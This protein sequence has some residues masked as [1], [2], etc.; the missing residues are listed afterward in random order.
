MKKLKEHWEQVY[1]EKQINE[2]SWY[3]PKPETSLDF[4][5][6]FELNKDEK[7]IDVGGGDSF[8]VDH[9]LS[10]GF[11]D[12]TVLDISETAISRAKERLGKK[13]D[14]IT[15]IVED[16]ASFRPK[17]TYKLWHDR[18]AFHFLTEEDQIKNYLE[19]LDKAVAKGGYVIMGAF[20]E[21]GPE[22]CSG[23]PVKQYS[24]HEMND[25]FKDKFE[26][27]ECK[28]I[29]HITPSK[30]VQNFTFCTFKKL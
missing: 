17:H 16:A 25:L 21:K 27:L 22:K 2:V 8:L 14:K 6:D 3:Q 12:V 26:T 23:I 15:W 19:S 20:S 10:S 7:I 11:T 28:N 24:L 30:S 5:N 13:A 29:D 1:G 9:L 4:I 18:A